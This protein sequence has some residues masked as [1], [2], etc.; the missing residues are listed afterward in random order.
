MP[1]PCT[2]YNAGAA[3][4]SRADP[5]ADLRCGHGRIR[6]AGVFASID[7]TTN[8]IAPNI[9]DN[10]NSLFIFFLLI[11]TVLPSAEFPFGMP[12]MGASTVPK[13]RL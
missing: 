5:Y 11:I 4:T 12:C 10:V 2:R 9:S 1:Y 13:G 8:A 7:G 6:L 3:V